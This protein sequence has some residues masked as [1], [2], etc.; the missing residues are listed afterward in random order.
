MMEGAPYNED[1]DS[2]DGKLHGLSG[3][4]VTPLRQVLIIG[5]F[6]KMFVYHNDR[7]R[8]PKIIQRS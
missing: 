5:V 1:F 3:S 2:Y 6:Y 8:P 7:C 4:G